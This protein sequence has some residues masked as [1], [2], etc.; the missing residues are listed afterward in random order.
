MALGWA[1]GAGLG[2]GFGFYPATGLTDMGFELSGLPTARL[3]LIRLVVMLVTRLATGLAG[4]L[5][6]GPDAGPLKKSYRGE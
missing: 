2:G 6:N 1:L 4:E 3:S 5:C